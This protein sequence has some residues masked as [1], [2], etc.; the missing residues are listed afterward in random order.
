MCRRNSFFFR[1]LAPAILIFLLAGS[2][3]FAQKVPTPEEFLG[4]KVGAD[5]HLIDYDQALDY[6]QAMDKASPKLKVIELGKTEM[7]RPMICAIISSAEN[8]GKLDTYKEIS[9]KLALAKGLTDEEAKKLANEGKA[10]VYIDGGLHATECAPAQHNVQLAY[11]M[12]TDEDPMTLGI[13]ENV[14]LL[15]VFANPDGMQLLADWYHPNVGTSYE[16]SRM[17]WVYNKYVGHDNNRDSYMQ[18]MKETQHMTLLSADWHPQ[19]VFNHHQTAPFPTRIWIHPA[20]E[21]VMA[22]IHPLVV[23]WQNLLGCAQGNLFDRRD[24]PGAISRYLFDTWYPGYV[25]N[26]VDSRNMISLLTETALYRYATPHFYTVNDFPEDYQDFL[27]SVFYPNPWKGGWWR[28]RD[29]VEYVMTSSLATLDAA[30]KYKYDLLYDRYKMGADVI[31]RFKK[32][33]PYAWII[34]QEQADAPTAAL[35][36]NKM[37]MAGVEVCKADNGFTSDG[38]SY[39]AG[40]WVIPMDQAFALYVKN[41]MEPQDYPD[42]GKHPD[43]WQGL[44]VPQQFPDTYF[45]PYDMAGWTLPFQM[46]VKAKQANSPLEVSLTPLKEAISSKGKVSGGG[47]YYL[48]TPEVNN[49]F[50]AANRVFKQ[51]GRILWAKDSFSLGGKTWPAGTMIASGSTGSS[52]TSLAKELNLD[53]GRTGN[54]PVQTYKLSTPRI[55]LYKSWTGS[56]DEGWTRW[57]FEQFEFKFTNII[58]AEIRAGNLKEDYDVI[59]IPAM[60]TGAIINGNEKGTVDPKYVGGIT[61]KGVRNIKQFVEEGGVLVTLNGGCNFPIDKLGVP[62]KDALA[63]LTA[64]RRSYGQSQQAQAVK[65]ACPGSVLRASFNIK[66]PVAYGMPDEGSVLFTRSMA[67]NISASFSSETPTQVI[68]KY[69]KGDLLMSGWLL[70]GK[71]LNDKAAAVEASLGKGKVILLGFGVQSRAQPHGT[72][73]MLFNS[74]LYSTAR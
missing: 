44:V 61:E 51:G 62:V 21:P 20:A 9:T 74:L 13:L 5:F 15:L 24:Q 25:A 22:N 4:F 43:A 72:F 11:D 60:S 45:P 56:M 55:A 49:S 37:M 16:V 28:L 70:G 27:H 46:N 23:R 57:I 33:P 68:A 54:I 48:L 58:D 3:T 50:I 30:A 7:G 18:N 35:M 42:L 40:T 41:L 36:L 38:I 1:V 6:F 64:T 39:P 17:P 32:E 53:I 26:A 47:G 73:K 66:H 59:V 10:V 31:K 12:I 14:I 2:S 67:F 63:G 8:M 65:F 19:I 71:H 29:A 52:M 69:P 34:P